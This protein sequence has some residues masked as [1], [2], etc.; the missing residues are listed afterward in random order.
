MAARLDL[1]LLREAVAGGR[2]QWHH[3]ALERLLERGIS[4]VEVL[5][6]ITRG[7]IIERYEARQPHSSCLILRIEDE[8]LHVVVAADFDYRTCYIVTVYRPDLE[9]F[10]AD[11]RTRRKH[12]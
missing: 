10:E 8:P 11:F 6:A 9:H 7:E 3:H 2:I 4:R 12:R 5:R 1:R